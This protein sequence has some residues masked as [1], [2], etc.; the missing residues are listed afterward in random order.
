MKR[1]VSA[2][3]SLTSLLYQIRPSKKAPDKKGMSENRHPVFNAILALT[4]H[5]TDELL[6]RQALEVT[7]AFRQ[8]TGGA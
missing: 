3:V 7:R 6:G 2:P 1:M 8:K 5:W 4:V